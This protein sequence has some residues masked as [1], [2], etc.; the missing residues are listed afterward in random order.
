MDQNHSTT[1]LEADNVIHKRYFHVA[2][3]LKVVLETTE[4]WA[5]ISFSFSNMLLDFG[6][7]KTVFIFYNNC[8]L[9]RACHHWATWNK[10]CLW[11]IMKKHFFFKCH[12]CKYSR[13]HKTLCI[14]RVYMERMNLICCGFKAAI[15]TAPNSFCAPWK[16]GIAFRGLIVLY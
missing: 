10:D 1:M 14:H 16:D 8:L 7:T 9:F 6:L 11:L 5:V 13:K 3:L 2:L 4:S 12:K 15:D